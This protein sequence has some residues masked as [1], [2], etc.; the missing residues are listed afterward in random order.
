MTFFVKRRPTGKYS[1]YR[2]LLRF[3]GATL[4]LFDLAD[5]SVLADDNALTREPMENPPVPIEAVSLE[6]SVPDGRV[7]GFDPPLV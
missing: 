2:Y 1:S 7:P 6:S 4:P 5:D 3:A